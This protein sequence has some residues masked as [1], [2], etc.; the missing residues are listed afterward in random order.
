LTFVLLVIA[1]IWA[2]VLGHWVI[3]TRA[4]GRP[5]DSIGTFRH[6]LYV[7]KRTA[8]PVVPPANS[9][10]ARRQ[11][12]AAPAPTY[13]MAR[14][15][16]PDNVRRAR[17]LRR[18]RD[19]LLALLAAMGITFVLAVLGLSALW[20]LHLI[21]D[22]AFAGYVAMLVRMRNAAAERDMKLRFLPG[23]VQAEPALLLRRSAN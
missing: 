1:I 18:R 16:S 21:L 9:L 19:V 23:P 12:P 6:Q 13:R 4:E 5:G 20:G 10:S 11:A 22:V 7:L 15:Y 17:T 14:N 8:P 3:S 2:V